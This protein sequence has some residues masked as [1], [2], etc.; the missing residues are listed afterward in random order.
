MTI[1]L[2]DLLGLAAATVLTPLVG[3]LPGFALLR[4]F[5]RRGFD[6]GSMW[7]RCGWAGLLAVCL[8][9]AADAV[10]VRFAGLGAVA[11]GHLLLAAAA[12]PDL[13]ARVRAAPRVLPRLLLVVPLWWAIV[14]FDS[15]DVVIGQA[16]Y[17]SQQVFDTVKHAAVIESIDQAGLP[18]RDP[19]FARSSPSGYYYYYYLLPAM[20]RRIGGALVDGRMAFAAA[21]FWTGLLVPAA[22]WRIARDAELVRPGSGRRLFAVLVGLCFVS[23]AE[24]LVVLVRMISTGDLEPE[25]ASGRFALSTTL[26]VPHHLSA[27]IAALTGA[28]LLERARR[29]EARLA[30][31]LAVAAGVA[32]ATTFGLSTWIAVAAVPI[33]ALWQIAV[34]RDDRRALGWLVVA[35]GVAAAA[36]SLQILDLFVGRA[37][38]GVPLAFQIREARWLAFDGTTRGAAIRLAL[39]PLYYLIEFGVFAAGAA[40]FFARRHAR[41]RRNA[42]ATLLIIA[43]VTALIEAGFVRSTVLNNDFGW[44]SIWFAQLPAMIWTGVMLA[45]LRSPAAMPARV[46]V[47][48]G[49]GILAVGWDV[50]GVRVIRAPLFP[51]DP[52]GVNAAPAIDR[53]LRLAYH[54]ANAHLPRQAVLQANPAIDR[55]AFDFGLY[56]HHRT[57]V[58]DR[59]AT[60]FGA[61]R[62]NVAGRIARLRS[63]F[64]QPLGPA[65]IVARAR[66]EGIDALVL[67]TRDRAWARRGGP[68]LPCLYRDTSV[69]IAGTGGGA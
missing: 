52:T 33:L 7:S 8:L 54:W 11:I 59:E 25:V 13:I 27:V 16:L 53:Q 68:G 37:Q 17:Q 55:R 42:V 26:W 15:V 18:L 46:A 24:L 60:L 64:E 28:L 41:P 23:S 58:A 50:V 65:E 35:T 21:A 9:P 29:A 45:G 12:L 48:L 40:W 44:R 10:L 2:D 22:L 49:I 39:L 14:A 20:V 43:A 47:L 69:C 5:E 56:G 3:W 31:M 19:F 38:E 62:A 32:W 6:A 1:V 63:V 51:A 61:S 67:T 57:A 34:V 66:A 30:T 36:S 4:L